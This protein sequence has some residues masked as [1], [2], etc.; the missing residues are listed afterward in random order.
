MVEIA[1]MRQL[2]ETLWLRLSPLFDRALDLEP[3]ARPELLESVRRDSPE[4]ATTLERLLRD[5]DRA[6][7]SRFLAEPLDDGDVPSLAGRELGPYTLV[8]LIGAGGMGTVWR[9]RRSDGRFE[10][11]VA[12]KLLHLAMLDRAGEER[13]RREGMLLARLDHPNIAR[14]LDAGVSPAGQPYLVLELVE[15]TLLDVHADTHRLDVRARLELFAQV[16]DAVA[17]AHAQPRRAPRPQALQHPRRRA[18]GG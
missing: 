12:V 14:L 18:A 13:F 1:G 17:H 9:A 10:K 15:G 8:R 16:A 4:L 3:A 2:D 11:D 7:A 5:H 6:L